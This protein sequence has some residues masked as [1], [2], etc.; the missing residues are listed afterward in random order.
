MF[1]HTH[2]PDTFLRAAKRRIRRERGETGK[3]N[4]LYLNFKSRRGEKIN[5]RGS[6]HEW[7]LGEMSRTGRDEMK[8]NYVLKNVFIFTGGL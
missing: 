3:N 7:T 4:P 6:K 5:K 1:T 2:T 8:E